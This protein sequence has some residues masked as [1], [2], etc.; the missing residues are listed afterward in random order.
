MSMPRPPMRE[1]AA[2]LP[3]GRARLENEVTGSSVMTQKFI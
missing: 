3:S 1:A 2:N